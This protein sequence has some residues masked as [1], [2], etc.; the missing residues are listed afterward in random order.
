MLIS[1]G[2]DRA[3]R[4][5]LLRYISDLARIRR[6]LGL[7]VRVHTGLPD[8]ETCAA[9]GEIDLDG[10]MID[11]IGHRDTVSEVYHLDADPEDYE[12]ALAWLEK[13][14]V[15]AVPHIVLGLH[16][17]KMLGEERALEM[18]RRHALKL[19]VLVILVPMSRTSM[20]GVAP[21]SPVDVR[22]FLEKA[23]VTFPDR[24]VM[25]GCERPLG[26]YKREVDRYAVDIG[27]DGI[28][29][30]ADE[31]VDYARQAGL[32]P[33]FVNACCGVTW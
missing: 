24:P 2:S 21:P 23:R 4:V 6:D 1:G 9:L 19:L 30:P 11:I 22:S 26:A 5:P 15:P 7:A 8:E 33:R 13:Y 28:A 10:A 18:I 12:E 14:H 17:G 25:L 27:L 3:G 32:Q 31:I 20:A 29:F 16:F